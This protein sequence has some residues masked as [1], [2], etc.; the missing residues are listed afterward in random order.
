MHNISEN[1]ALLLVDLQLGLDHPQMGKRNNPD[2]EAN[3]LRLLQHWRAHSRPLVHI[4]HLSK[5][6]ESSLHPSKP[7]VAI[8]PALQPLP[9][10]T[11]ITKNVNSAFIGT[12]LEAHL[13]DNGISQ[14]VICGLTTNHCV[15][16]TTRM[17]ENLGFDTYLVADATAA[18]D[19]T[20]HNGVYHPAETIHMIA[21][22][23][24]NE[25]FAT[26]LNTADLL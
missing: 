5:Y 20:D 11:H 26:V 23:N 18:H 7:G 19:S 22:A 6:P 3:C 12:N 2:A 4:Q 8:K 21:L 10:E 13:R 16:T 25:E 17:A 9:G 14:V 15:S 24:L 1:A